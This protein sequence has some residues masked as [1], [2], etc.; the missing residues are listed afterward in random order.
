MAPPL[1]TYA[2]SSLPALQEGDSAS[3]HDLKPDVC[4]GCLRSPEVVAVSAEDDSIVG[5]LD[6]LQEPLALCQVPL[7]GVLIVVHPVPAHMPRCQ[8]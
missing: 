2:A 8:C 1:P 7:P 3:R 5:A 6:G 4:L